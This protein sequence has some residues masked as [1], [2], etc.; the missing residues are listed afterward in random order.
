MESLN[1][2][3]GAVA[4]GVD[5][6]TQK[7]AAALRDLGTAYEQEQEK[8]RESK[9][10]TADMKRARE[11]ETQATKKQRE[12][13]SATKK[14][15][16][17]EAAALKKQQQ[18][19]TEAARQAQQAQQTYN[20]GLT[21]TIAIAAG[22]AAMF[23]LIV[24]AIEAGI[25]A[26]KD[27]EGAMQSLSG[28]AD[29]TGTSM[30]RL[31]KATKELTA[32]GLMTATD[33]S[34]AIKN[35]LMYGY[36]VDQTIDILDRLKDS[37]A[38]NRQANYSL[39]EAVKMTTEGIRMENS[40]LSDAAG[41]TKNIAK[42]YE[43]YARSIGVASTALT[44]QQKAQGVYLGI[45][46][47]TEVV[48]GNAAKY[49]EQFAGKQA[50]LEATQRKLNIAYG[51]TVTGGLSPYISMLNEGTGALT[52]FVENNRILVSILT[53]AGLGLAAAGI[54][55]GVAAIAIKVLGLE[56][57]AA[58]GGV[59]IFSAAMKGLTATFASAWAALGPVGWVILGITA[60]VTV[61]SA[62]SVAMEDAKKRAEDLR[63][64]V[65]ALAEDNR[66]ASA[67]VE[68]YEQLSQKTVQ[69]AEE[70]QRMVDIRAE[71]V[72]TYGFSVSAVDAE[73]RLLA[74]NL[75]IMKEQ[76]ETSKQLL[77]TK[78]K[79]SQT[80]DK[81][82]YNDALNR[83]ASLLAEI[84]D[85]QKD[86]D[87]PSRVLDLDN[88][89]AEDIAYYV[90]VWKNHLTDLYKQL[91][92]GE[93]VAS[94]AIAN[95]IQTMVLEVEMN[96]QEIP[97]A[98]QQVIVDK[99]NQALKF[100]LDYD[101]AK[102]SGQKIL[103]AYLA[104]DTSSA[105]SAIA[106][107]EA[108]KAQII[109]A[110]LG[111]GASADTI[112]TVS[113][114]I[115]EDLVGTEAQEKAYARAA[116]LKQKIAEGMAT[117]TEMLE[118]DTLTAGILDS[119]RSA[120]TE[121]SASFDSQSEGAQEAK[122][123]IDKLS[124]SYSKSAKALREEA[125]AA[126]AAKMKLEDAAST[127]RSV[128]SSYEQ[129]SDAFKEVANM[130]AALNAID[131][132][133]SAA[134]TSAEAAQNAADAKAYL[135]EQ[136]GVEISAIDE[137][138]P[139]IEDDIALK[140]A[141]ALADYAVGMQAA[142]TAQAQISAMV[143]MGNIT[144]EQA[145]GMILALQN[146]INKMTELGNSSVTLGG[147]NGTAPV[148][149]KP[150][151]SVPKSSSRSGGGGGGS[152]KNTALERE[153]AL[154]EH[155]KALDQMTT[156][157][158]IAN[159]ERVLATYAK[160]SAEKEDLIEKIYNL[161]KKKAEEDLEFQKSM[162]QLTL[163][164]E[165]SMYGKM[166]EELKE[167]TEAR[168]D[169]EVKRYEAQ[170]E[171][172]RQEYNL[173]VYYGQLSLEQ[174]AEELK[175]MISQYKEGTE[176]R[177]DLE[178]ELYEVQQSIK[179]RDIDNLNNL[180]EATKEAL[181][182]RYNEQRDAEDKRLRESSEA[183]QKWGD[184]RV[185][186]IQKQIDA[187]DEQS[188]ADDRAEEERKKRREIAMLEQA[189]LYENDA[190][191]RQ[192]IEE[193]IAQKKTDLEK[194]LADNQRAD[195]KKS[196]Q[197][198]ADAISDKVDAEKEKVEKQIEA[199]D[200]YYDNLTKEENLKNEAIKLLTQNS[201]DELVE[202]LK[203]YAPEYDA[204]GKTLGEKLYEGFISKVGPIGD[205]FDGLIDRFNGIKKTMESVAASGAR[206]FFADKNAYQLDPVNAR[207]IDQPTQF[208][209][210]F[211]S[212]V[213]SPTEMRREAERLVDLFAKL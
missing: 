3:I 93:G 103:D 120:K 129:V 65:E 19:E 43:E 197:D 37:A 105:E 182:A 176:A 98:V 56:S 47:E 181:E 149:I 7:A 175:K 100:G 107:V 102:E 42:M 209:L 26:Y 160:T 53:T 34:Y 178:K 73:G 141:L 121:I 172:A 169:I 89:S 61:V 128:A 174:Q 202:L 140:E 94:E 122:K 157:E 55:A 148:S 29:K 86:I 28:V 77:I 115:I 12:E 111:T 210:N 35:L 59:S 40:I 78:L 208:V 46:K 204:T 198:Q 153:L 152:D 39:G 74:G 14:A 127:L 135:A 199:N 38:Y 50:E 200:A 4:E 130:K 142:L 63:K 17:E 159:L 165:I 101:A 168:R 36:T 51:E 195:L 123:A 196:M 114:Q 207:K 136:Y 64:E 11:E 163:R 104:I 85:I 158:E 118:Y 9:K 170:K 58:A 145:D 167:N 6:A 96:G 66:G 192:K 190:Y 5:T 186:A 1:F 76:L 83:R 177:I 87:N 144:Q 146:V 150:S 194:W 164:E 138:I 90:G 21:R 106:E 33:V 95:M 16:Q 88:N 132:Y 69:T 117:E 173:K 18:A 109:A 162:D 72:K 113:D 32:D 213:T 24:S 154:I 70:T 137:M 180:I 134:D 125:V 48:Q 203:S 97:D 189:A 143:S 62:V 155:K 67:L 147:T 126:E 27:Y 31:E 68:E 79:D 211:N 15:R 119:L 212:P 179:E 57:V 41:V 30:S 10:S 71:L 166:L 131:A 161:K 139:G 193:Q 91:E 187:L 84:D 52:S 171:L 20:E 108:L 185:E 2:H 183:W 54:T 110:L 99:I 151:A 81:S 92:A 124:T 49:A 206:N 8:E 116:E 13:I 60:L 82:G 191:N 80:N 25:T 188:E 75:D 22:A 133:A 45:M 23:R 44:Q 112:K 201:Q 205:F 184:E 156:Q